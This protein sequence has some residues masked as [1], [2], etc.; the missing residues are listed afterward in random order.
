[1]VVV[2]SDVDVALR[3]VDAAVADDGLRGLIGVVVH[4]RVE[5]D[6]DLARDEAAHPQHLVLDLGHLAVERLAA[7][8]VAR[9]A[10]RAALGTG[11]G[12]AT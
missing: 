12:S 5:R 6:A 4:Q 8:V 3:L 7:G 9:T 10:A 2:I 11:L 1:M